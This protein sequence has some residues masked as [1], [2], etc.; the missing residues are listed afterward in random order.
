MSEMQDKR[1]R[2]EAIE[3]RSRA[4]RLLVQTLYQWQISGGDVAALLLNGIRDERQE[5]LD[6][7]YFQEALR[8][9]VVEHEA[10]DAA[11]NPFS[12]RKM[13]RL[14]PVERG[15]LW[16]AA[17][18]LQQRPDVPPA[19]VMNEAIELAKQFGAE[20][21]YK[22]INGVLDQFRKATAPPRF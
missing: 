8:Y 2:R 7:A 22:F 1:G 3:Q 19:V 15:I 6:E 21:S 5:A 9:I 12:K 20:D 16:L 14:D 17:Y 18:E 11:V 4:R 13:N 10:L